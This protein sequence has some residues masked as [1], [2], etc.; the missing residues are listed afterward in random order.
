MNIHFMRQ[1]VLFISIVH[2][3]DRHFTQ[4]PNPHKPSEGLLWMPI[5]G[6]SDRRWNLCKWY[7]HSL[8]RYP[9]VRAN[10]FRKD[11]RGSQD[12][13]MWYTGYTSLWKRQHPAQFCQRIFSS[14]WPS[15]QVEMG[16]VVV[17]DTKRS[18]Q[19]VNELA[20]TS[21]RKNWTRG[22]SIPCRH[23]QRSQTGYGL[24]RCTA[25]TR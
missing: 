5:P 7:W 16:E 24:S 17:T 3:P 6:T 1:T 9:T 4:R 10:L 19:A 20:V 23:C 2:L 15:R 21:T 8:Y 25:S 18:Y 22:T 13:S 14:S 12:R 11:S